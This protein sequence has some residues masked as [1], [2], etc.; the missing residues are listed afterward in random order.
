M[1]KLSAYNLLKW[2][3]SCDRHLSWAQFKE[4]YSEFF[5]KLSQYKD[6]EEMC[7]CIEN[8]HSKNDK[9]ISAQKDKGMIRLFPSSLKYEDMKN[10]DVVEGMKKRGYIK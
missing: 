8:K 4:Q 3:A 7:R 1:T 9:N 10:D 5:K 6:C 2:R